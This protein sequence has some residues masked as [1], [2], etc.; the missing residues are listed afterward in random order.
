MK[1]LLYIVILLAITSCKKE[2]TEK[3]FVNTDKLEDIKIHEGEIPGGFILFYEYLM[4]PDVEASV[5]ISQDWERDTIKNEM[6][7]IEEDS[8]SL[9]E[10]YVSFCYQ[11]WYRS[12]RKEK[13]EINTFICSSDNETDKIVELYTTKMYVQ[14]FEVTD[15]PLVGDRSWIPN[16]SGL[17]NSSYSIMF[18][19]AN[20][21]ARI[22]VHLK[23][24]YNEDVKVTVNN[25]ANIVDAKILSEI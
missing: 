14:L 16:N 9:G 18:L 20:V 21:F 15:V 13:I 7:M 25:I 12:N 11:T 4:K 6:K 22:Y 19:R 2:E 17:K 23:E 8:V 5:Q 3:S 10:S 24:P 1:Y